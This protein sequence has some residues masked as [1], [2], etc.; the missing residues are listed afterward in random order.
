MIL[1]LGVPS[2]VSF[3]SLVP[4]YGRCLF[5]CQ[6]CPCQPSMGAMPFII[7]TK[8]VRVILVL[9]RFVLSRCDVG[10]FCS[11]CKVGG[12]GPVCKV[13]A[14][15][16]VCDVSSCHPICKVDACH[17]SVRSVP[18]VLVLSCCLL[19]PYEVSTRCAICEVSAYCAIC[20]FGA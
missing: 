16:P 15:R 11:V 2:I 6:V 8:L 20:E 13:G 9:G 18:V 3:C 7:S 19:Y 5:Q 14:C 17:R 4:V 12:F 10:T 1:T